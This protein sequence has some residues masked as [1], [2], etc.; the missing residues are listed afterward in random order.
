MLPRKFLDATGNY[1]VNLT[2]RGY[3]GL[4]G[5]Y[6]FTNGQSLV[7]NQ[8]YDGVV[9]HD[10]EITG[11]DTAS[12]GLIPWDQWTPATKSGY[13]E[14]G[15]TGDAE[16]EVYTMHDHCLDPR[17]QTALELFDQRF[18]GCPYVPILYKDKGGSTTFGSNIN[19]C[20]NFDYNELR[21]YLNQPTGT[22]EF[23]T[24]LKMSPSNVLIGGSAHENSKVLYVPEWSEMDTSN[25][26]NFLNNP[27]LP[28]W[29]L[30][31]NSTALSR[32]LETPCASYSW[33]R[34][35]PIRTHKSDGYVVTY[36][37]SERRIMGAE[38]DL[39]KWKVNLPDDPSFQSRSAMT[40]NQLCAFYGLS[41]FTSS[42]PPTALITE[43]E[44]SMSVLAMDHNFKVRGGIVTN[45]EDFSALY[46][47]PGDRTVMKTDISGTQGTQGTTALSNTTQE[48][49]RLNAGGFD[50]ERYY[51]KAQDSSFMRLY[52]G[53]GSLTSVN[54]TIG[55][56]IM[57]FAYT[58]TMLT[59]VDPLPRTVEV[60]GGVSYDNKGTVWGRVRVET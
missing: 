5:G 30:S 41:Q 51:N 13:N 27:N 28:N 47:S 24:L 37:M 60:V 40:T 2:D 10:L 34:L 7:S 8:D 39:I 59:G 17:T 25:H 38:G 4:V 33:G 14:G 16:H 9:V 19:Y 15:T 42:L 45:T 6:K 21:A 43:C 54:P 35:R 52:I 58:N 20:E 29:A 55:Q 22:V 48:I 31:D 57:D 46:F 3:L 44:A 1:S 49:R 26:H 36:T 11:I 12:A 50:Y 53:N 56:R 23:W 32:G 18:I